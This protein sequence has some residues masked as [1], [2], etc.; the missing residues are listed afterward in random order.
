MNTEFIKKNKYSGITVHT[1]YMFA[2]EERQS[3]KN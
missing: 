3:E 1:K 2:L